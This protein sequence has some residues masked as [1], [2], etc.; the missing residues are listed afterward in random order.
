[1][2]NDAYASL[3]DIF[4][5]S[6]L[7]AQLSFVQQTAS[8]ALDEV[9]YRNL[10]VA[11]STNAYSLAGSIELVSFKELKLEVPGTGFFLVLNPGQVASTAGRTVIPLAFSYSIG[12][13]RYIPD[14]GQLQLPTDAQGLF[15]LLLR[16]TGVTDAQLL[17]QML[18]LFEPGT[19]AQSIFESFR[20]KAMAEFGT[21]SGLMLAAPLPNDST[22]AVGQILQ[23]FATTSVA[24]TNPLTLSEALL[25]LYIIEATP[26]QAL[27]NVQLLLRSVLGP[28]WLGLL[29]SLLVPQVRAQL[30]VSAGVQVPRNLLLPMIRNSNGTYSVDTNTSHYATIIFAHGTLQFSTQGGF[31][32]SLEVAAS[33]ERAQLGETGLQVA[34]S[35]AKLDLSDVTNISEADV[36]GRPNSFK[37]LYASEVDVFL[38]DGWTTQPGSVQLAAT[39][40]LVGTGGISGKLGVKAGATATLPNGV[41]LRAHLFRDVWINFQSFEVTFSHNEVISSNIRGTFTLETFL[42]PN[43]LPAPFAFELA[44]AADGYQLAFAA[45]IV[46]GKIVPVT[47]QLGS[48]ADVHF[49]KMAIGKKGSDWYLDVAADIEVTKALP[50]I[51]KALPSKIVISQLLIHSDPASVAITALPTW[52][53]GTQLTVNPRDDFSLSKT[54]N[55]TILNVL[56]VEQLRLST[57]K[58]PDGTLQT[59]ATFDATLGLTSDSTAAAPAGDNTPPPGFHA[60]IVNA[61]FTAALK[62]TPDGTGN[63][64]LANIQLGVKLPDS[65]GVSVNA[66]GLVGAGNLAILDNGNRY[67]GVLALAFRDKIN[68]AAYGILTEN[69]PGGG[70]GPSLLALITAQFRAI[71]LGLGFTLNAVGG[72]LGLHRAADTD[73][74]L[75]LV[76][77]GQLNKLLFP[78]PATATLAELTATLAVIDAA[79]PATSGRYLIGL[80]A[81][82]GW[83]TPKTLITLDVALLVELPSPVRVVIL[84]VL[85]TSLPSEQNDTLKLRADFLGTVDFGSKR[86]AFDA[87]LSDSHILAFALT[88]DLAF[89]FYQGNNPLFVITAGGFHP[90]FQPPA[91]A[92][93]AGLR[94]LT[95]SLSRGNDLRVT[96]TSYFAVTSNTVQ[97]GSR[98]E[99][100]YRIAKGLHVEGYFGFDVLFQF[101]PFHVQAHVEAGVA[102]KYGSRELLSLHLSLDVTGPGP[103]H[104]WGSASFKVWFVRIH[105]DVDAYIGSGQA[106]P[107]LPATDVKTLLVTALNAPAS[108]EVEAPKTALPGGVVLRPVGTTTAQF[109][110]DP[111]GAL[112]LRQRVVPLGVALGKYGASP[113]APTMGRRFDLTALVVG[114]TPHPVATDKAVETVRDFF[115]PDQ[116]QALTDAQKLSLPSF[117]LLPCGLRLASLAGLVADDKATLRVVEYEHKLISGASGGAATTPPPRMSAMGYQQLVRGGALGQEVEAARPSARAPQPLNWA[118]EAYVVV[119]AA[120]LELYDPVGH[121]RFAT[122]VEAEQ[123]RQG[124]VAATPALAEE[125][126]VV[127]EYQLELA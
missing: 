24:A 127:P 81:R 64:A 39:N 29:R 75:G 60:R 91:G 102:I 123:Y 114:G 101:N 96:L 90:A 14:F 34:F 1:M 119:H 65:V 88:G 66:G 79:F 5:V 78:S 94:R 17:V 55:L 104:L 115:A 71:E 38:P 12:I 20:A 44:Y 54:L 83:G 97:F 16:I 49:T 28:N 6:Q 107:A 95:L 121:A 10:N 80:M 118:E 52:D 27:D 41:L 86:A 31:G 33:L 108:W 61:G 63:L 30:Q 21:G 46:S 62:P 126:L 109:F 25:Q 48:L 99:L 18:P 89:R 42:G 19:S 53:D 15:D 111:R 100:Y 105:V 103:W 85:K 37:G 9:Y 4:S 70:N 124:L 122:Q 59:L 13:G 36:D 73:N 87:T 43:G 26:T 22:T 74:L 50:I 58:D 47:V 51:G 116:F 84:G 32:Y 67:E 40:L 45:P 35:R 125:V 77:A 3:S 92:G 23:A 7:P 98:L 56:K 106:E 117:Q 82:L 68:L 2:A 113:I 110:L 69:L 112:V 8:T 72:L 57:H 76:R 11:P 120:T 93:L